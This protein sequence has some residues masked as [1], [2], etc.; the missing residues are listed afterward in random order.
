MSKVVDNNIIFMLVAIVYSIVLIFIL[1]L[2]ESCDKIK[3]KK[4][5]VGEITIYKINN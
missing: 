2:C 5:R 3:E 4:R 1:L